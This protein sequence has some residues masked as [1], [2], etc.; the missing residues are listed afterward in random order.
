MFFIPLV[1]TELLIL[2]F[3]IIIHDI[4]MREDTNINSTLFSD[5]DIIT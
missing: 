5:I 2:N 4:G 3:I 1:A